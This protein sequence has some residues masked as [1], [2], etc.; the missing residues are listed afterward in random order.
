[1]F[2]FLIKQHCDTDNNAQSRKRKNSIPR[3]GMEFYCEWRRQK[4][5]WG[6]VTRK[7]AFELMGQLSEHGFCFHH[8]HWFSR[9]LS[10]T[11]FSFFKTN[12]SEKEGGALVGQDKIYKTGLCLPA[13]VEMCLT[14][15]SF[16]EV[17]TVS[18]SHHH[19]PPPHLTPV[20]TWQ[21]LCL[22]SR[23]R[24]SRQQHI[25]D[26]GGHR[27]GRVCVCV[28]ERWPGTARFS[29]FQQRGWSGASW[30]ESRHSLEIAPHWDLLY[31]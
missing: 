26:P 6:V 27:P 10:S 19:Q 23:P 29:T 22:C 9:R 31:I 8:R 18:P 28:C 1:M 20:E 24:P 25:Q 21:L 12:L 13:W 2:P 11:L 17:P 4:N 16:Q 7:L 14:P 3:R 30:H 5:P 15:S